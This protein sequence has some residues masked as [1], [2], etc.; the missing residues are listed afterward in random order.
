[1]ALFK[2]HGELLTP[3]PREAPVTKYEGMS[4]EDPLFGGSECWEEEKFE[5]YDEMREIWRQ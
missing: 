1:M 5:S 3:M 2:I 4:A